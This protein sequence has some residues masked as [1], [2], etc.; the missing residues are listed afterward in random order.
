MSLRTA[1]LG[2]A[3]TLLEVGALRTT[4]FS[5]PRGHLRPGH[6]CRGRLQ[7]DPNLG[8]INGPYH[9]PLLRTHLEERPKGRGQH[10]DA[11]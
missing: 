8:L 5:V 6:A 7:I 11:S 3:D 4:A 1:L 10:P 2:R 9:S